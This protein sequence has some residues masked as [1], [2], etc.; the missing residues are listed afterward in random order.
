MNKIITAKQAAAM[1]KDGCTL[2]TMGFNGFGCPE[3][4]IMTL[5]EHHE[6]TGHP[7]MRSFEPGESWRWCYLDRRLAA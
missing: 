2:A 5:A 6:E 3:D 4:L 1:V 7:V